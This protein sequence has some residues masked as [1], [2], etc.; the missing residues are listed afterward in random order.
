M[1][2]I[3]KWEL[4]QRKSAL[5]GWT[6]ASIILTVIILLVYPS[7]RDQAQQ[8]NKVINTLPG[9][10]RGLKTGSS[11][12]VDVGSPVGFLNSQLYYATLPFL[13]IIMV[14]TRFSALLG[15]DEQNHTLELLLSRP[16]SRGRVLLGKALAGTL[17]LAIVSGLTNLVIMILNPIVG[18]DISIGRLVLMAAYLT[19]FCLSFGAITLAI[20]AVGRLTKR[21]A[22]G[23][24]ILV[25]LGGYILQS[26]S[27]LTHYLHTPAKFAPYH[28]FDPTDILNGHVSSG[29][30]AYLLGTLVLAA[31]V[32]YLGFRRRDIN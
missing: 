10:L 24:A 32:G 6:A 3:I 1:M 18:L 2:P 7:I 15:R 4:R 22:T 11:S 21:A 5:F 23:I 12:A 31:T 27:G 16:I 8:L 13:L 30:N 25:S 14:V 19:L 26:M 28:Y 20:S 9:G 17:E 29:L